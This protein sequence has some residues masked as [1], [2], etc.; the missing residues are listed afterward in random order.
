MTKSSNKA[1]KILKRLGMVFIKGPEIAFKNWKDYSEKDKI[2]DV[3][4]SFEN[5]FKAMKIKGSIEKPTRKVLRAAKSHA[6]H[7]NSKLKLAIKNLSD[8]VSKRNHDALNLW[9]INSI[10][11]RI[12]A[13]NSNEKAEVLSEVKGLKLREILTKL[14]N[15]VTIASYLRIIKFNDKVAQSL[16]LF[17]KHIQRRLKG[18][19]GKWAKFANKTEKNSLIRNINSLKLSQKLESVAK[20]Q[21]RTVSLILT[22]DENKVKTALKSIFLGITKK[23]HSSFMT[24]KEFVHNTN[25][26]IIFDQARSY[27]LRVSLEKLTR[28]VLKLAENRIL[29]DGDIVKAKLKG[30]IKKLTELPKDSLKRW[31][32]FV[33]LCHSQKM[34]DGL[35][36]HKLVTNLQKIPNR[37]LR[38][39][40]ERLLGEGNLVKGAIKRIQSA[41]LK[42]PKLGLEM[43]KKYVQDCKQKKFYDNA[44]SLNLKIT[45]ARLTKRTEKIAFLK[46]I[47][48][49]DKAKNALRRIVNGLG[50]STKFFLGKWKDFVVNCK[51]KSIF[52]AMRSHKLQISLEK[53]IKRTANDAFNRIFENGDII[54]A[55]IRGV[56]KKLTDLP[57]DAIKRWKNYI[58]SCHIGRILD[59]L[60]SQK[61]NLSLRK[62]PSRTLR[63]V[64]ERL[65]GE[66][67]LVKG[68]IKRI[69]FAIQK[70]PKIAF[71]LWKKFVKDCELKKVYDNARSKELKLCMS[72]ITKRTEKEGFSRMIN[73]NDR[74][75][76]LIRKLS[77]GLSK[78]PKVYIEK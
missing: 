33:N 56:I 2:L 68:A 10:K 29:E 13:L 47:S 43:W 35:R 5:K 40:C 65:L 8:H 42:K 31:K 45:L 38:N 19:L 41:I 52:D 50:K 25:H 72:R 14:C 67:S 70:K 11:N 51:H 3:S 63:N 69:E 24:W 55:K 39:A 54:K 4:K 17:D 32:N 6:D 9:H 74:L 27:K 57:K 20:R 26:K 46:I 18:G 28:R 12:G 1:A 60:R 77:K 73:N 7:D 16:N 23:I 30:V 61:L 64:C 53:L 49:D 76:G 59:N 75:K 36:S 15:R 62:I 78:Q 22:N 44:R 71:D 48:D 58:N 21:L 34:L 66:G 37:T